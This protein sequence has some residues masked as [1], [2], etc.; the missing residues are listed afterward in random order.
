M[1][2]PSLLATLSG[3]TPMSL[4]LRPWTIHI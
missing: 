3:T 1:L 4:P 2:L